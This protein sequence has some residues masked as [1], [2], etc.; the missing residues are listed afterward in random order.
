VDA[1][2]ASM[3]AGTVRAGDP[4]VRVLR[5]STGSWV[6]T[7]AGQEHWFDAVVMATHADDALRLL[8][9]A[10]DVERTALGGFEYS[11]NQVVLHTDAGIL[12]DRPAAWASWNVD[13]DDCAR[14]TELTM[15]YHM[16]RLQS[17]PGQTQYCV[18]INPGDRISE[19]RI[20]VE[21]PMSH[22]MYTF[23]TLQAQTTLRGLQGWRQTFYAGAHLGYGFHEDG[24]RSG[25]EAA[26]L[27]DASA[28]MERAA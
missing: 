25:L 21:R 5:E 22:P 8:H 6:R 23:R 24:C 11:T 12:P 20:I 7:E 10:D 18:S 3:P 14:G 2:V 4:V 13:Q 15:T 17:L 26:A 27:V 16:N 9:D 28:T 19:E 1:I